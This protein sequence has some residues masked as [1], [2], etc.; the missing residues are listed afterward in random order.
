[1]A[2]RGAVGRA[3]RAA[4][5]CLYPG[6][7]AVDATVGN[8][9]D[10]LFLAREVGPQGRVDGVDS[11]AAA[12]AGARRRLE[13]A[14]ALERVR[15]HHGGHEDLLRLLPDEARGR[16]GAVLFNLG[17]LPGGDKAVITR[18][19]TTLAAL[20]AAVA[21]LAPEGR[22]VLVAYPG[23][24]GGAEECEAVMHWARSRRP[25]G[26][27]LLELDPPDQSGAAPR[28]LV[29]ESRPGT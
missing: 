16:V 7:W 14:G 23:H 24:P 8:G 20:E 4:A 9:H 21:L 19:E 12:L 1:M 15:L 3:H 28:L 6:A 11:Q 13:T 25:E 22:I 18:A 26:L 27:A 2:A 17:Y 5:A 29:L 10:T